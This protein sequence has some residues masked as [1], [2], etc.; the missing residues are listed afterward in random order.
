MI[1]LPVLTRACFCGHVMTELFFL[2]TLRDRSGERNGQLQT[3]ERHDLYM[4]YLP[5][6]ACMYAQ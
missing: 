1:Q 5:K 4:I 6:Y 2:I 3:T